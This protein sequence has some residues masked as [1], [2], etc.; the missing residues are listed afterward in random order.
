MVEELD[1]VIS[2]RRP[3]KLDILQQ[4]LDLETKLCSIALR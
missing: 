1:V 4:A 3:Q 2:K